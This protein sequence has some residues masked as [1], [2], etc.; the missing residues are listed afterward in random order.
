[1]THIT[2]L[3]AILGALQGHT[4]FL[5]TAVLAVLSCI[6]HK[7]LNLWDSGLSEF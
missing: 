2:D 7:G 3:A 1:M 5:F 4:E 6:N